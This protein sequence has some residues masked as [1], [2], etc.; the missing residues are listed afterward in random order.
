MSRW[1]DGLPGV[2]EPL[3]D[4]VVCDPVRLD[5]GALIPRHTPWIEVD[6]HLAQRE[7]WVPPGPMKR[8][9]PRRFAPLDSPGYGG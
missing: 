5:T 1:T 4:P 9:R 3:P 7:S 6:D 8:S 2:D